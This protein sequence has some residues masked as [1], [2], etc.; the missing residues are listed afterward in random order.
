MHDM[1]TW[2]LQFKSTKM[3]KSHNELQLKLQANT[4]SKSLIFT[5]HCLLLT[6]N[7]NNINLNKYL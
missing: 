2:D 3:A 6:S 1:W 4:L 7:S 5:Y